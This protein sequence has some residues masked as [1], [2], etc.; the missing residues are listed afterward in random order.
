MD[1]S[2]YVENKKQANQKPPLSRLRIIGEILAGAVVGLAVALPLGYVLHRIGNAAAKKSCFGGI[3]I[4]AIMFLV[5]PA[6][7]VFGNAVGVYRV[8]KRDDEKASFSSTLSWGI[9]GVLVMIVVSIMLPII[10]AEKVTV[11]DILS[12]VPVLLIPP[13]F[14]T[15]G[16][17]RSRRYKEPP[18][19]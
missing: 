16:F 10:R 4:L 12:L 18:S 1:E 9:N 17:N 7:Y 6:A 5:I 3:E 2:I 14:A 15:Y 11:L 13:I 19:S 8:G